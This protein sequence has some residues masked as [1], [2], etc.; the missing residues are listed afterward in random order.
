[1]AVGVA[2]VGIGYILLRVPTRE[3]LLAKRAGGPATPAPRPRGGG[4]GSS[5]R[6]R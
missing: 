2:L 6:A 4:G 1:V 3:R 5:P